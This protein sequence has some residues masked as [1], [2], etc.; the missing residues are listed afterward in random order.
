MSLLNGNENNENVEIIYET[1]ERN[2]RTERAGQSFLNDAIA[3]SGPAANITNW[4][5]RGKAIRAMKKRDKICQNHS[6]YIDDLSTT[7]VGNNYSVSGNVSESNFF[8]YISAYCNMEILV[9]RRNALT[10]NVSSKIEEKLE[11]RPSPSIPHSKKMRYCNS[12]MF[13]CRIDI[14]K[15]IF[16][17]LKNK[18][19]EK[20][21]NT[22]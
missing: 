7:D 14:A 12:I 1:V 10:G 11:N 3:A 20:R 16:T 13:Q 4:I 17:R 19:N 9:H 2:Y 18:I 21:D 5:Y 22:K 8:Q 15:E 6:E